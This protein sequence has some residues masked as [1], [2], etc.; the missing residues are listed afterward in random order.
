ME[1]L[2]I[3][4][5]S[6]FSVGTHELLYPDVIKLSRKLNSEGISHNLLIG[7]HMLHDYAI[8]NIPEAKQFRKLK[9]YHQ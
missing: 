2:T 8:Q 7:S 9:I 1:T 3:S 4:V 6:L 5:T